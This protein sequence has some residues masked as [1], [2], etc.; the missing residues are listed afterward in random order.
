[1][2]AVTQATREL[3]GNI[4]AFAP[5]PEVWPLQNPVISTLIWVVIILAIFVPLSIRQ[6]KRAA[7]RT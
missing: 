5:E 3:F 4:P 6:Y 1:M 7:K 2:S